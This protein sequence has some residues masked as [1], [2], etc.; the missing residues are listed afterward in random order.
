MFFFLMKNNKRLDLS[1]FD[2]VTALICLEFSR[3]RARVIP[4]I[5]PLPGPGAAYDLLWDRIIA[6]V[7][8]IHVLIWPHYRSHQLTFCS[9]SELNIYNIC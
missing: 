6:I 2:C 9:A 3:L 5:Q 7:T 8:W 4:N 1:P